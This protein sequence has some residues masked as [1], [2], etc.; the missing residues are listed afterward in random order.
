MGAGASVATQA[1]YADASALVKLVTPEPE[2]D[3][4]DSALGGESRVVAS[5]IVAVELHCAVHRRRLA[6][7]RA[8]A[9]LGRLALAPLDKAILARARVPFSRPLRA[10]DAI[11]LATALI[12]RE[13]IG[14]FYAYGAELIEAARDEGMRVARPS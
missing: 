7:E 5:E 6:P 9:V 14:S 4:L 11:H 3:A 10:L 1:A 2:S 13:E 8:N 12:L